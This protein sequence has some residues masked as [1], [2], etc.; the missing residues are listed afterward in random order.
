MS[1][2]RLFFTGAELDEMEYEVAMEAIEEMESKMT[3]AELVAWHTR[4]Y[5]DEDEEYEFFD[6][7]PLGDDI[8]RDTFGFSKYDLWSPC[9]VCR[10][11]DFDVKD[12]EDLKENPD[13]EQCPKCKW[14][15]DDAQER[16]PN[17]AEGPNTLSLNDYRAAWRKK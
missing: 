16:N 17:L 11:H 7:D 10:L 12:E 4:L 2:K 3:N 5:L 6:Y 1:A 8:F 9:P 13:P 14:I 15:D